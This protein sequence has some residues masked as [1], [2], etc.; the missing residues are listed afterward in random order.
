MARCATQVFSDIPQD[1]FERLAKQ[2]QASIG[3]SIDKPE[4]DASQHGVTIRWKY[5]AAAQ[6]LELQCM[7]A[8]F[9]VTCGYINGKIHDMLDASVAPVIT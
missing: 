6:T 5:D 7:S 2:V 9:I 3:V 8:P 4:G 1:R